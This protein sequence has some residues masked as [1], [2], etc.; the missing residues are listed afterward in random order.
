M[1]QA[2]IPGYHALSGGLYSGKSDLETVSPNRHCFAPFR[3]GGRSV[4][5]DNFFSKGIEIQYSYV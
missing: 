1:L 2:D 5:V 3:N 4:S